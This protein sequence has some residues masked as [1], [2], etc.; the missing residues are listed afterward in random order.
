MLVKIKMFILLL[1]LGYRAFESFKKNIQRFINVG[2]AENN[3][4]AGAGLALTG[5]FLFIQFF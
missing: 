5:K 3:M 4:V 2:V 1:D